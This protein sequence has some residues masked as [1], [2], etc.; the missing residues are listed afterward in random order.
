MKIVKLKYL[1]LLLFNYLNCIIFLILFLNIFISE[2]HINS[3]NS[4]GKVGI[5]LLGNQFL[6]Q[7]NLEIIDN[8]KKFSILY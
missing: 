8:N 3:F 5:A 4:I 2:F 7:V 6:N 1:I